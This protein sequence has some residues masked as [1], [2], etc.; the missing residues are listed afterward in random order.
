LRIQNLASSLSAGS[1]SQLSQL[2]QVKE[3]PLKPVK[4]LK[5][6]VFMTLNESKS[7]QHLGKRN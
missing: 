2:S 6:K 1:F 5:R 4:K 3:E 7:M